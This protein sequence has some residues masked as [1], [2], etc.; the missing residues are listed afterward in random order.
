MIKLLVVP[1][2]L[3][4]VGCSTQPIEQHNDHWQKEQ[5]NKYLFCHENAH[6]WEQ[7]EQCLFELGVFI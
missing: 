1:F 4:I 3:A 5:D 6:T 2:I 7:V